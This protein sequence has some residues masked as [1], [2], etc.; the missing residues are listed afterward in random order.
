MYRAKL[1]QGKMEILQH[2]MPKDDAW[3]YNQRCV[4]SHLSISMVQC[5]RGRN[6]VKV[7]GRQD[8]QETKDHLLEKTRREGKKVSVK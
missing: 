2:F 1:K 7:I 4:E 8:R 6:R 3:R 5:K